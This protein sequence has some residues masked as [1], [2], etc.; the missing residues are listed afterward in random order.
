MVASRHMW[1]RVSISPALPLAAAPFSG[2]E[3]F[4]KAGTS[5][6]LFRSERA[7]TAP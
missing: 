1:K 4:A 2:A 7:E 5:I 6:W 3:P